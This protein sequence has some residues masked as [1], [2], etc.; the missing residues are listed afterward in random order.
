MNASFQSDLSEKLKTLPRLYWFFG[1]IIACYI[2][3]SFFDH[4]PWKP[5]DAIYIGLALEQYLHGF[6]LFP[7]LT[8][9]PWL[10]SGPLTVWIS[11]LFAKLAPAWPPAGLIRLP[12][13][14][15]LAALLWI[16]ARVTRFY[17]K[18]DEP[19]TLPLLL[20]TTIGLLLPAHEASPVLLLCMA[21]MLGFYA[22]LSAPERSGT[23][24]ILSGLSL[25]IAF[26]TVGLNPVWLVF[27]SMPAITLLGSRPV[28]TASKAEFTVPKKICYLSATLLFTLVPAGVWLFAA[29][30]LEPQ[31]L[32]DWWHYQQSFYAFSP[33]IFLRLLGILKLIAW[34]AFPAWPLAV[35]TIYHERSHWR[36]FELLAPLL[37]L[38]IGALVILLFG[39]MHF[40]KAFLLILPCAIL[41][42]IRIQS[43]SNTFSGLLGWFSALIFSLVIVYF[44]VAWSAMTFG[45][46]TKFSLH[47]AKIFPDFVHPNQTVTILLAALISL[48]W[49]A[50][51]TFG[52]KKQPL[53]DLLNWGTGLSVFWATAILLGLPLLDYLRS[54][55]PVSKGISEHITASLKQDKPFCL[56]Y[57][58]LGPTQRASLLYFGRFNLMSDQNQCDF[59]IVQD[60]LK[61][62]KRLPDTADWQLIGE[63]KRPKD[64]NEKYLLFQRII[65]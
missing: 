44:W 41:G 47:L 4:A 33:N 54:Y 7:T 51:L 18:T 1:L 45:I 13:L 64:R 48:S 43:L 11:A 10:A 25:S 16:S 49:L 15:Y 28:H 30:R 42:N 17:P 57:R 20:I 39:E 26:L 34:T 24:G 65:K 40:A 8:Q 19:I 12:N 37:L 38:F 60:S 9:E 63:F 36:Q 59:L 3:P 23:A 56:A 14:F 32:T 62:P 21:W 50:Y 58:H 46:P 22:L 31:L 5:A 29:S 61:E 27:L 6:S 35:Y 55:E 2:L 52:Q 53:K